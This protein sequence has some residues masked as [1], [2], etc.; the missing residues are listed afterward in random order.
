MKILKAQ[1]NWMDGF[2]NLPFL[3]VLVDKIPEK[4]ELRYEHR[5][6]IYIAYK[7]GYA[8]FL[9]GDPAKIGRGFGGATFHLPMLDG[10]VTTLVGPWSSRAAG[11]NYYFP[12]RCVVDVS[13]TD[14]EKTFERGY[15]FLA[16]H[17]TLELAEEAIK[18]AGGAFLRIP[19][20]SEMS[21]SEFEEK[22]G[23]ERYKC[24]WNQDVGPYWTPDGKHLR[25]V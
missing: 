2:G 22:M 18:L 17:I 20:Q 24:Y 23:P 8:S 14:D 12:E 5:G 10:S 11:V 25:S 13:I 6:S 9:L 19:S 7:G 21:R 4:E 1:I 16:G 15:T 3:E